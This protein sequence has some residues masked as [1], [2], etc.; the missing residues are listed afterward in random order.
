[1]FALFKDGKMIDKPRPTQDA[2]AFEAYKRGFIEPLRAQVV[3]E[4]LA[5]GVQ[6]RDLNPKIK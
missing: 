5:P 3:S 6:I 1:M 2:C 4:M